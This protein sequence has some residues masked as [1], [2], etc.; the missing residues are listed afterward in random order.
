[1]WKSWN[2]CCLSRT[3]CV[4]VR[5]LA[6]VGSAM[7]VAAFLG[8]IVCAALRCTARYFCPDPGLHTSSICFGVSVHD[9]SCSLL[10]FKQCSDVA[11]PMD[12]EPQDSDLPAAAAGVNRAICSCMH[13][14]VWPP[15]LEL[16]EE[17]TQA[18]RVWRP[19]PIWWRE[20]GKRAV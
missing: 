12:P 5:L 4:H 8:E 15:Q 2:C 14:C 13:V 17:E 3:C 20:C 6:T 11:F 7:Q 9:F 10:L 18:C 19:A 1:M 16:W